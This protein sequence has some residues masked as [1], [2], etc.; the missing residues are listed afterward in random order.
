MGREIE[1]KF[2]VGAAWAALGAVNMGPADQ[3]LVDPDEAPAKAKKFA[4]ERAAALND[5][6][7]APADRLQCSASSGHSPSGPAPP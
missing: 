1:R 3:L 7:T 2:L 6:K 5:A 4:K